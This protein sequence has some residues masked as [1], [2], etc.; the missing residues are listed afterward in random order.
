MISGS[1]VATMSMKNEK[2]IFETKLI[3]LLR[4]FWL[5]KKRHPDY[6]DTT[7]HCEGKCI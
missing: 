4:D 3:D 1:S 2:F 5:Y 7:H 6:K